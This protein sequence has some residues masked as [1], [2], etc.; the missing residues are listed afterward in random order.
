[1]CSTLQSIV[2]GGELAQTGDICLAAIREGIYRHAQPLLS[3]DLSIVRSRMGRSAGLVGAA[4]RGGDGDVRAQ[5][6]S[7]TGSPQARRSRIRES[8]TLLAEAELAL[9]TVP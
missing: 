3:R 9:A 8:S 1:M 4:T 2:I 5:P 6:S 7:K